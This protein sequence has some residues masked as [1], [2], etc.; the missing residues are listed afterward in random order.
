ME[1][2]ALEAD[3]IITRVNPAVLDKHITAPAKID[4]VIILIV[5]SAFD[6][7]TSEVDVLTVDEVQSPKS[8]IF[9]RQPGKRDPLTIHQD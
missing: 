3:R 5:V 9:V 6:G 7:Y 8:G 2:C 1:R 4:T